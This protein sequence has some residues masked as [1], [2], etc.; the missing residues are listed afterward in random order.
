MLMALSQETLLLLLQQKGSRLG[1]L[2]E[3][4]KL[5]AGELAGLY[6]DAALLVTFAEYLTQ[7]EWL[8]KRED[9]RT[10][11]DTDYLSSLSLFL[12]KELIAASFLKDFLVTSGSEGLRSIQK[13]ATS[14]SKQVLAAMMGRLH[15][16]QRDFLVRS[17][18]AMSAHFLYEEAL[19]EGRQ[20]SLGHLGPCLYSTFDRLDD[21]FVLDYGQERGIA[22][23]KDAT[24]RLY[25]GAGVGVQSGYS[26]ILLALHHLDLQ[27]GDR[28]VDLGSGYGRVG[29]VCSLLHPGV[30]FT[31]YEYVTERVEVCNQSS[32]SL[33]LEGGLQ[34]IAQ[35]LSLAS[36]QIPKADV[37]YLY[38]PFTEET[39]QYV[40][41]QIVAISK[42][43]KVRVVTKGN[44]R[45]WLNDIASANRWPAPHFIDE[46]N[47]GLYSSR[48]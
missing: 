28:V 9:R 11:V 2:G 22:F 42:S 39:Y 37:Y 32:R 6:V 4:A 45:H 3:F 34:F 33:G 5:D 18:K 10:G 38:D 16:E 19:Q 7:Q 12:E 8:Q 41:A 23:E 43:Q 27:K 48:L 13:A 31:G 46:G 47:L 21:L 35:D 15:S 24:E 14:I 29:L 36:F 40:L 20:Q 26:T 17:L 44:A 25:E 30:A 1:A